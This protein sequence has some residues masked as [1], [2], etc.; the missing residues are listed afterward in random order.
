MLLVI[1]GV[2][3]SSAGW[4]GGGERTESVETETAER[5][6]ITQ[7]VTASGKIQPEVEVKI[8][9]DVSGEIIELRVREGNYVEQGDLL[10]RI[11][12]DSY[13]AALE[14]A[15]ANL[16]QQHANMAERQADVMQAEN[17]LNRQRELYERETISASDLEDAETNYEIA[18]ARLEAAEF[19]VESATANMNEIDEQ[20]KQTRIFAPMSGTVSRL[21]V[22]LGERVVGTG[23][24]AGTEMMRIARLNQM[25]VEI[26]VNENDV[27]NVTVGDTASIEV[28]AYPEQAFTGIVTEIANSARITGEGTQ[29]Q[30]T[31]FP[32][33]VRLLDPHNLDSSGGRPTIQRDE[34]IAD[35]PEIAANFRPGMSGTV[36]IFTKT[37]QDV[38]S[39][40]IQA[41][42]VRDVSQLQSSDESADTTQAN[43][44]RTRGREELRRVVFLADEGKARIVEVSTG[45]SDDTY[46]ELTAG[47]E[48]GESVI[49]G[50]YS[51]VSRTLANDMAV[52]ERSGAFAQRR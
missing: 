40:P 31:N 23:Q 20:L 28:D 5:R 25:E 46:I 39:V 33:K 11:R 45:I 41:V 8:S 36:D 30:I 15:K 52:Q 32:V 47:L 16:S 38:I 26:D 50:P 29:E 49:I 24:M 35:E 1:L 27:V 37:V 7:V 43:N 51:A 3:G 21:E 22:E 13:E 48:G 18:K 42:T 17:R 12:P 10:A 14:Q 4:W 44:S 2:V 19:S 9:P 34:E 6:T